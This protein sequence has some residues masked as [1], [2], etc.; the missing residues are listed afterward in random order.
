MFQRCAGDPDIDDVRG[1]NPAALTQT[2]D[3]PGPPASFPAGV[4]TGRFT[5]AYL[6]RDGR[7]GVL[8]FFVTRGSGPTPTTHTVQLGYDTAAQVGATVIHPENS[9][10]CP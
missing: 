4:P 10:M 7:Y 3:F 2:V 1:V 9:I 8:D 5:Y 6:T